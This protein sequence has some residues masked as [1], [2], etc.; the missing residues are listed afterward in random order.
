LAKPLNDEQR[1]LCE[2]HMGL[3]GA[4]V[5]RYLA[6]FPGLIPYADDLRHEGFFALAR[7]VQDH[8][9][10]RGAAFSTLAWPRIASAVAQA[11]RGV[12]NAGVVEVPYRNAGKAP[13]YV[14]VAPMPLQLS[15]PRRNAEEDIDTQ[16]I[17]DKARKALAARRE[18]AVRVKGKAGR[19]HHAARAHHP[20]RDAD[21]FL[22]MMFS[23]EEGRAVSKEL[24]LSRNRTYQIREKMQAH[25]DSWVAEVREE[26]A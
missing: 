3:V 23:D 6:K 11:A 1:R 15:A 7:T 20:E 26:A 4:V 2:K 10:A 5:R 18:K 19:T 22:R 13:G 12:L 21:I 16:Q 9:P 14:R 17:L 24:G 25:F 8:D